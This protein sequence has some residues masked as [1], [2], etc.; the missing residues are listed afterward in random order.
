[1]V[2][3]E[4]EFT[5]E[6]LITVEDFWAYIE[7]P[8]NADRKLELVNGVIVEDTVPG[9]DHGSI[10]VRL[11]VRI[12]PF[13]EAHDLG[14]VA[15][16]VDHYRPGDMFNTRRPDIEFMSK[17]RLSAFDRD[18]FVPLMP[19]LAIEVKSPSNTEEQL[20]Q[21][22]AYY[23]AQGCRLV[24]VFDGQTRTAR[25]HRLNPDGKPEVRTLT[26]EDT[27]DGEDVLPGFKLVLK[28]IFR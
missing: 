7:R 18:R 8:E 4:R 5:A 9:F 11:V 21:K 25:T 14:E 1:M 13:V 16:E 10:V 17:E 3:A 12:Q 27:L 24:W 19:D 23:L 15:T 6:Q 26:I 2:L 20:H 28:D 22:A